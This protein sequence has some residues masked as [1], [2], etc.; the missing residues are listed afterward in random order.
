[1]GRRRRCPPC[2]RSRST[3]PLSHDVRDYL[4]ALRLRSK[5]SQGEAPIF[6]AR[7]G[8]PLSHRNVSQRGFD[9]AAA[10]AGISGATFHDL[11]HACASRLIAAGLPVTTAAS[12]LGHADPAVTLR[13]YAHL[14]DRQRTDEQVPAAMGGVLS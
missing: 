6:A 13:V 9:R 7:G 5:H 4:I 2:G 8:Q 3:I 11:R 10:K 1:M 12:V 14:W